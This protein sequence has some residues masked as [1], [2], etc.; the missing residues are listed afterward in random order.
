MDNI[1]AHD[2]EAVIILQSDH[3]AR[4]GHHLAEL[5]GDPYDAET[6]TIHQQ[7]IL[8]CVYLPG[9]TVDITGLNGINTL[10]TVLNR[11][12]QLDYAM[13]EPRTGCINY[14]P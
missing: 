11:L 7:N 2:P 6:D 12:F 10:R 1:Q 5:Y 3:G 13:V 4:L 9:E 14:Y 8:N